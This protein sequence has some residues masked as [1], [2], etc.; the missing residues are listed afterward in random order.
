MNKPKLNAVSRVFIFHRH[1]THQT[2]C[3]VW[4]KNIAKAVSADSGNLLP[5]SQRQLSVPLCMKCAINT[6]LPCLFLIALPLRVVQPHLQR[7]ELAQQMVVPALTAIGHPML[8]QK[9]KKKNK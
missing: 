5:S 2:K 9:K 4:H 8:L 1:Q 6:R 3:E 7:N